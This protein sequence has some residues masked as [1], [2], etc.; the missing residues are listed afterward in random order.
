MINNELLTFIKDRMAQG[1]TREQITDMLVTHGGWNGGDVE[2]A[3]DTMDI[4]GSSMKSAMNMAAAPAASPL[5]AQ[6]PEPT[7]AQTLNAE[8]SNPMQPKI[9][10]ISV[11]K[12]IVSSTPISVSPGMSSPL[13]PLTEKTLEPRA[14]NAPISISGSPSASPRAFSSGPIA[15]TPVSISQSKM[16][17]NSS[18]L[19]A[20]EKIQGL[21]ASPMSN[22]DPM[23]RKPSMPGSPTAPQFSGA[24]NSAFPGTKTLEPSQAPNF[25][26]ARL[27]T[28]QQKPPESANPVS[29]PISQM[30]ISGNDMAKPEGKTGMFSGSKLGAQLF[31]GK[32]PDAPNIL[33]TEKGM[34]PSASS[35]FASFGKKPESAEPHPL[36]AAAGSAKPEL[37]PHLQ[38]GMTPTPG[39]LAA[40]SLTGGVKKTMEPSRGAAAFGVGQKLPGA[41]T[42]SMP[43]Q[44]PII[45]RLD[46]PRGRK[47]LGTIMLLMGFVIGATGMHAYLS[48]YLD[49]II[50]WAQTN[51]PALS[52]TN[53]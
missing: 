35:F 42:V 1:S 18:G 32:S 44:H 17:P 38:S 37:S 40:S 16:S 34:E 47:L 28:F 12:D 4:A 10:P 21:S 30:V 39:A 6:T 20:L 33:A 23:G 53:S 27:G 5:G 49:P 24:V 36:S 48:G 50:E 41:S 26:S 8:F 13:S 51:I 19:S 29:D 22:A 3:F 31:G 45:K 46:P 15:Q 25:A 43:V 52:Q 9:E 11:S 2:E 7:A 14:P